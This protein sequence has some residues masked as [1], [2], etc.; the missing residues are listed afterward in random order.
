[1]K[2]SELQEDLVGKVVK[3]AFVSTAGVEGDDSQ[4]RVHRYDIIFTDGTHLRISVSAVG[5]IERKH[6]SCVLYPT[7]VFSNEEAKG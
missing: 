4:V 7:L 3:I 2:R 5:G 1:M 6:N